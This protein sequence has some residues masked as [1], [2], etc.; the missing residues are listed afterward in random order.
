MCSGTDQ[1]DSSPGYLRDCTPDDPGHRDGGDVFTA[2]DFVDTPSRDRE[3]VVASAGAD[4][5]QGL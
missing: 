2:Q 1:K 3:L 4:D 5:V